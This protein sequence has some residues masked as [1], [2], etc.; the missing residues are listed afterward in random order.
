MSPA[1][2]TFQRQL[3]ARLDLLRTQKTKEVVHLQ[4]PQAQRRA[5][6]KFQSFTAGDN[7]L[8]RN[9]TKGV[10]WIPATVVAKTGPVSYTV[11]TSD[12]LTWRRHVD[13]LLSASLPHADSAQP[14]PL[15]F[16]L[17]PYQ[18]NHPP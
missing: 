17:L 11:E 1:S 10:K 2:A 12:H 15:V 18:E 7:V 5:K 8:A 16:E 14:A 4:R 3:R 6:A 9:Y 13:Q